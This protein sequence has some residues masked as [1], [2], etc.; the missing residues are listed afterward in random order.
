MIDLSWKIAH[1]VLYTAQHLGSFGLPVP[2]SCFCGAPVESLEHL[3]F[4]CPLA[5][6]VLSW[7][8]SLLF[9]FSP[10][11]PVIL[12]RHVLFGFNSDE[13]HVTPRIFVYLLNLVKFLIWHSWNDLGFV[14]SILVL[15][16][17]SRRLK[18]MRGSI[19]RSF[20]STLGPLTAVGTFIDSGV[21]VV[22]LCLLWMAVVWLVS[23]LDFCCL[24]LVCLYGC[25]CIVC[26]TV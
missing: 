4:L 24:C 7:L 8:Q 15:L 20:L 23:S 13:L 10:M 19:F 5:Q 18:C 3:F 6:S 21:L 9:A 26:L 12:C 1:G 16:R 17:S 14:V 2:L 25:F 22:S 11:C